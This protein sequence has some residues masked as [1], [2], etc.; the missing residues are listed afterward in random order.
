[1]PPFPWPH[2]GRSMDE[3]FSSPLRMTIARRR[4]N[5][6]SC[7]LLDLFLQGDDVSRLATLHGVSK[8]AMA[9]SLRSLVADVRHLVQQ[10]PMDA[11]EWN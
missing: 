8:D 2:V 6:E 3:R 4:L 5:T 9:C 11:A 1:M 10:V 7:R